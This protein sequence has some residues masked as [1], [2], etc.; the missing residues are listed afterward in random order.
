MALTIHYLPPTFERLEV[1]ANS[2][3]QSISHRVHSMITR[4]LAD[5]EVASELIF[6]RGKYFTISSLELNPEK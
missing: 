4:N 2:G 1:P 6:L 5:H 3:I